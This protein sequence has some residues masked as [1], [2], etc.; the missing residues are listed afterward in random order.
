SGGYPGN[1]NINFDPL[2]VDPEHGD[3]HLRPRSPAIDAG[4]N[5]SGPPGTNPVPSFDRD[6]NPR[7]VN[8]TNQPAAVTDMGAYEYQGPPYSPAVMPLV[9]VGTR[10]GVPAYVAVYNAAGQ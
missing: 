1:G 5:G 6:G 9:A 3:F 7:P 8:A 4:T 2:F 10:E